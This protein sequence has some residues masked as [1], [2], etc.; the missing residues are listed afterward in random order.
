MTD[1]HPAT[2][3]LI[4]AAVI[5]FWFL[6]L[7]AW[8]MLGRRHD[9]PARL[10][11]AGTAVYALT[12]TLYVL[13]WRSP[14][15]AASLGSVVASTLSVMLLIEAMRKETE[16]GKTPWPV[17]SLILG[18]EIA[19]Q[20]QQFQPG[21]PSSVLVRGIHL[22]VLAGLDLTLI[23]YLWKAY[24][25]WQSSSLTVIGGVFALFASSN[26]WRVIEL[27][28]TPNAPG[29][30]DFRGSGQVALLLNM[31]SVVFYSF[32]YWGFVLDKSM[33]KEMQ[34]TQA[35]IATEQRQA[36]VEHM[37]RLGRLAQGGALSASIAHE[38]N[39]PLAAL[40]LGLD[41]ALAMLG[42]NPPTEGQHW[43]SILERARSDATRI[44]QVI[45]R[46]QAL[47]RQSPQTKT[48][49]DFDSVVKRVIDLSAPRLQ[50]H[51]VEVSLSTG[52]KQPAWLIP[53]EVEHVVLNLVDNAIH[54]LSTSTQPRC[55]SLAS[56]ETTGGDI[57]LHVTDNG[58]GIDPALQPFIFD[59]AVTN[60]V[61]GTGMGLWL[62]RHVAER[63]GGQL[64]VTS[65]LLG[66][67]MFSLTLP[68]AT[69]PPAVQS[70]P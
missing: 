46:V 17:Y 23:F 8:W 48:L 55:L 13:S 67:T 68:G 59:L 54:A 12:A 66:G 37:S 30:L 35:R 9:R 40:H 31:L 45:E 14:G 47:F 16:S 42:K 1:V 27:F 44:H 58:P 24:R 32:G 15:S 7:G 34:A 53:G 11:F 28:S 64:T 51:G 33:Q 61:G 19:L 39:Q 2:Q 56:E 5:Q 4:A 60:R 65:H 10:W 21:M 57:S 69:R 6:P 20:V 26:V 29:L 63:H 50:S 43:T 62:A 49:Q 70:A 3:V 38:I 41:T 52:V 36:L 18:L 25:R 22:S